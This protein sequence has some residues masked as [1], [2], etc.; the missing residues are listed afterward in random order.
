MSIVERILTHPDKQTLLVYPQIAEVALY[1]RYLA[2]LYPATVASANAKALF[3]A[4]LRPPSTT[5]FH[6][7]W[8]GGNDKKALIATGI[9]LLTAAKYRLFQKTVV[10]TV[11]NQAPHNDRYPRLNLGFY[12]LAARLA[13]KLHVHGPSAI[14]L[15]TPTLATPATKFFVYPHP[16]YHV[17]RFSQAQANAIVTELFPTMLASTACH[18]VVFVGV[19][20]EYKLILE[21]LQYLIA[22]LPRAPY[23]WLI[24]GT[25]KAQEHA[26]LAALTRF[27]EQQAQVHMRVGHLTDK[28]VDALHAVASA[29]VYNYQ[30]ILTSGSVIR[31]LNCQTLTFAPSLGCLQDLR[32]PNLVCFTDLPDLCHLFAQRLPPCQSD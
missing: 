32:D 6:F 26:Y 3:K 19:I 11:H 20:S 8:I 15:M 23:Q 10:W 2:N 13:N 30:N 14:A 7:H 24:A 22:H 31:A 4:L 28:Q 12:R 1:N 29:A 18:T 27:A 9:V 21:T 17:H 16:A 25:A 5:A